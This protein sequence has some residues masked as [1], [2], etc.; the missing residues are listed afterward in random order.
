MDWITVLYSAN[1]TLLL[2]HEIES[3]YE[4]EWE[5]LKLPGGITGFLL[6]TP[7][8]ILLMFYGLIEVHRG[9]TTGMIL[10]VVFGVSG[11]LPLLVHRFVVPWPE[12][13]NRPFS[14]ILF[15]LNALAGIALFACSMPGLI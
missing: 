9:S 10:G 12:R 1:A 5:I 14:R 6:M 2:I 15:L 3:A 4:R 7:S 11:L 13:F 8:I